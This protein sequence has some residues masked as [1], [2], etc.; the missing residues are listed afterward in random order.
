MAATVLLGAV[1]AYAVG[2][3]YTPNPEG[4]WIRD[5]SVYAPGS[6]DQV[7]VLGD[8]QPGAAEQKFTVGH[9]VNTLAMAG[10]KS[11]RDIADFEA[12]EIEEAFDRL[13]ITRPAM[14][15]DLEALLTT[16]MVPVQ[17]AIANSDKAAF[18]AASPSFDF[19][20]LQFSSVG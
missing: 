11:N 6:A 16:S 5:P 8:L 12:D 14:A 15:T 10:K 7:N 1:G 2:E 9:R 19:S 17:T 20:A 18:D 4:D 3:L 13:R